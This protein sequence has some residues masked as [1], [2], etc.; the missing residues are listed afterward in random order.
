MD[1]PEKSYFPAKLLLFGEH[2]VLKGSQALA[3]PFPNFR[4]YW[5][6]C[7]AED[8]QS[9]KQQQLP[10]LL[11]YLKA[12]QQQG[13]LL[14]ALQLDQFEQD[15]IEGLYFQSDI[16][17]GY[18]LGSSGA[19][20]TGIYERYAHRRPQD[21]L[22]LKG[23]LAQIESFFHGSSSGIDPLIILLNRPVLVGKD[24][25]IETVAFNDQQ[26]SPPFSFFLL[27]TGISRQTAPFVNLFLK[28]CEQA[29]YLQAIH[30]RL[31]VFTDQA[32]QHLLAGQLAPL[33]DDLHQI[34]RF[35]RSHFEEMIPAPFHQVWDEGLESQHFALKLCGA[36][37]G[38]FL[39]GMA[40]SESKVL[41]HLT[42]EYSVVVFEIP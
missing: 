29:D 25:S 31:S 35:Q 40:K 12:L 2:T 6:Y 39:L 18:G 9:Q 34:S 28:K 19:L 11:S 5:N 1:R 15:L 32:I 3:I 23:E 27:D 42:Q 4:G 16:P 33:F 14:S 21:L 38:G 41:E 20:C 36:G 8:Q 37:G 17:S 10:D 26:A 13:R 7:T 24:K 22:E 30:Q